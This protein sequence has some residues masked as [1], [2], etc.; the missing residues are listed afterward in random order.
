MHLVVDEA[1]RGVELG[2]GLPVHE[3]DVGALDGGAAGGVG[4]AGDVVGGEER[5]VEA[6]DPSGFGG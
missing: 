5:G 4:G 6:R 1:L 3:E 2:A